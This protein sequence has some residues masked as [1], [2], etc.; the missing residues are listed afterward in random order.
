MHWVDTRRQGSPACI[1]SLVGIAGE[2]AQENQACVIVNLRA[3][4]RALYRQLVEQTGAESTF[5]LCHFPG[6]PH[7]GY[8]LLQPPIHGHP[9]CRRK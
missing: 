9:P 6:N 3:H 1:L 4:A 7:Q 8:R 5:F 2:V